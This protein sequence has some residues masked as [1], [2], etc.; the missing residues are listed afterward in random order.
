MRGYQA[1]IAPTL[2][3]ARI[4]SGSAAWL[5]LASA[6][7]LALGSV[8][9][10]SLA[11][12]VWLALA[13][14]AWAQQPGTIDP[15]CATVEAA[16]PC[17]AMGT[18]SRLALAA[19]PTGMPGSVAKPGREK[20]EEA[21]AWGA[22]EILKLLAGVCLLLL[23]VVA[24][25]RWLFQSELQLLIR[26][27]T[28]PGGAD[29]VYSGALLAVFTMIGLVAIVAMGLVLYRLELSGENGAQTL[30]TVVFCI[31]TMA[32][33]VILVLAVFLLQRNNA[34]AERFKNAKE[35]LN[36]LVG[37]L[38]TIIGYYFGQAVSN[39][40]HEPTTEFSQ[41]AEQIGASA[42]AGASAPVPAVP[43]TAPPN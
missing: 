13:S 20:N 9:W 43:P 11:S 29:I 32:I 12:A 41:S 17:V 7:W 5:S 27:L 16:T 21:T 18:V 31:G 35:V 6:V 22:C 26:S 38:G 25:L 28:A 33:A 1:R 39:D 10:L 14:V 8:A 4:G 34:Y 2:V 24:G 3:V 36:I 40:A 23:L 19:T 15:L 37:I 30:I 42:P